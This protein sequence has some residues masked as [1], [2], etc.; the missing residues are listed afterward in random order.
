MGGFA[1]GTDVAGCHELPGV[2]LQGEPPEPPANEPCRKGRPG[3]AGQPAG[4]APLQDLASNRRRDE[5][6][7]VGAPTRIRLGA[8]GHP[9][10]RFDSPGYDTHH[11]GRREDGIWGR[12]E[13]GRLGREDPGQSIRPHVIGTRAEGEGEIEPAEEQGPARLDVCKV[14]VIGPDH[15]GLLGLLQPMAPLGEGGMDGQQLAIPHVIIFHC[16]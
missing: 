14:L 6:T 3:M 4:V 11:P 8:L 15:Y 1:A 16:R 10:G 7:V 12:V 2:C 9:D 5:K 13:V